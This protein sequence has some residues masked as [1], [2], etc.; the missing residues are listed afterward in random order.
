V[1]VKT[2]NYKFTLKANGI[3]KNF[4]KDSSRPA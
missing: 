3:C 2:Y 4:K 1:E